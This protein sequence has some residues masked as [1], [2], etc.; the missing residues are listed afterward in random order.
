MGILGSGEDGELVGPLSVPS[1]DGTEL[2]RLSLCV[3][4]SGRGV[5]PLDT[6]M[7][8]VGTGGMDILDCPRSLIAELDRI[9]CCGK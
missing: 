5:E 3:G 2:S 9:R 8:R 1:T 7:V 6:D 4:V